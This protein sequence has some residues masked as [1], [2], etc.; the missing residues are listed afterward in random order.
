MRGRIISNSFAGNQNRTNGYYQTFAPC[1]AACC[2]KRAQ[3]FT[4]FIAERV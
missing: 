4:T 1:A 3:K 2:E